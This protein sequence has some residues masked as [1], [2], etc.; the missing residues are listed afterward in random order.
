MNRM[1]L[2][3]RSLST[4]RLSQW[5]GSSLSPKLMAIAGDKILAVGTRRSSGASR[6]EERQAVGGD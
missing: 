2:P 1:L 5:T 6:S 3:P 4:G